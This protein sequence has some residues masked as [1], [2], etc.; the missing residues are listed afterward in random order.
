MKPKDNSASAFN[1]DAAVRAAQ[2]DYPAETKPVTFINLSASGAIEKIGAWLASVAGEATTA[3]HIA[4]LAA[5]VAAKNAVMRFSHLSGQMMLASSSKPKSAYLGAS[6][7]R[8][9]VFAF[10]HELGHAVTQ[11]GVTAQASTQPRLHEQAQSEI[12]A[13]VFAILRGLSRGTMSRS[14]ARSISLARAMKTPGAHSTAQA[15]DALLDEKTD[16]DI[17]HLSPADIKT[18]ADAYAAK[19]TPA[20]GELEALARKLQWVKMEETA[21]AAENTD[22]GLRDKLKKVFGNITGQGPKAVRPP[23]TQGRL[24]RLTNAEWL[25]NVA[26]LLA[27]APLGSLAAHTAAKILQSALDTGKAGYPE[28]KTFDV[29]GAKWDALRKKLRP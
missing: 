26:D 5:Q 16:A 25:E 8:E 24:R 18:T 21:P 14:E 13:D 7:A 9:A 19:F 4:R 17:A 3:E 28:K 11:N 20:S 15:I 27:T 1:F 23:E 6:A 22:P 29:S 10:D 12:A 2:K